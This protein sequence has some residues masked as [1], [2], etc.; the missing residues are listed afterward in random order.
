MD[1]RL[2]I[3]LSADAQGPIPILRLLFVSLLPR[4]LDLVFS[5]VSFS[6]LS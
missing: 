2:D 1:S 6:L 3:S 4:S 5:T